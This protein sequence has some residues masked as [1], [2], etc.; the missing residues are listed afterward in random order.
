MTI[1]RGDVYWVDLGEYDEDG[2]DGD[3]GQEDP[4][5]VGHEQAGTRPGIVLQNNSDNQEAKT[6]VIVPTTSGSVDEARH[7]NTIFIEAG[8]ADLPDD[9]IALCRQI[10]V[11]DVEERLLDKIGEMP[12]LKLREI[13]ASVEVVLGL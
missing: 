11:V 7:L 6:T 13:E 1:E 10:R 3:K 2:E 4:S 9:S 12:N 5:T 8:T